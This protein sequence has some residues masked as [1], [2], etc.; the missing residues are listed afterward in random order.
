MLDVPPE[1]HR[2]QLSETSRAILIEADAYSSRLR[3]QPLR[4][5]EV[6]QNCAAF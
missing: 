2:R 3:Q 6:A 5:K 4:V 1:P